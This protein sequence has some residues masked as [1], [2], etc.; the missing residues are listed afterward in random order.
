MNPFS[1]HF[2][3]M[4]RGTENEEVRAESP[5]APVTSLVTSPEQYIKHPLQNR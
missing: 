1:S 4:Q 3:F 2:A 5:T